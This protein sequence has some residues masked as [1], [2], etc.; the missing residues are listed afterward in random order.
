ME[1]KE[2]DV[3]CENCKLGCWIRIAIVHGLIREST[4]EWNQEQHMK[5][6]IKKTTTYKTGRKCYVHI[7]TLLSC[8]IFILDRRKRLVVQSYICYSIQVKL[9]EWKLSF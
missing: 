7:N 5:I 1:E 3:N 4:V 6:Y 8:L 9:K 2:D